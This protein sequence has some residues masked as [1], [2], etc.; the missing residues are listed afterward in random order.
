MTGRH[1]R[2]TGLRSVAAT[3]ALVMASGQAAPVLRDP[4]LPQALRQTTPTPA[5][6]GTALQARIEAKLRARFDAADTARTGH[7]TRAQA[8]AAGLG[9]VARDFERI[10]AA[11]HGSVSWAQVRAHLAGR[12]AAR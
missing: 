7:I 6:R 9:H 8:E 11:G 12:A 4:A 3:L 1:R 2:V 5:A 10:D